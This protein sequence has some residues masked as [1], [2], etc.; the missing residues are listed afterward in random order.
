M[1]NRRKA[2]HAF[3]LLR[4]STTKATDHELQKYDIFTRYGQRT[5]VGPISTAS[6][7]T[8]PGAATRRSNH[9]LP[10]GRAYT[11]TPLR[12]QFLAQSGRALVRQDHRQKSP[13]QRVRR[14]QAIRAALRSF[15]GAPHRLQVPDPEMKVSAAAIGRLLEEFSDAP[16]HARLRFAARRAADRR[17]S[18]RAGLWWSLPSRSSSDSL[19]RRRR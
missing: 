12:V 10:A 8:T 2:V 6:R 14:R 11:S 9:G 7:M 1:T 18:R 4:N 16:G 5:G 17:Q 13:A 15:R 19:V 3:R